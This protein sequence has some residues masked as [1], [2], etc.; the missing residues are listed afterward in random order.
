MT[1]ERGLKVTSEHGRVLPEVRECLALAAKYRM[2]ICSAHISPKE[3]M[4]LAECAQEYGI[5]EIIFSHPD[6]KSVG[7]TED[8]IKEIMDRGAV[9]EFCI[10]GFMP[11][12]QR[13]SP[14]SVFDIVERFGSERVIIT[15]D[16]F[17]DLDPPGAEMMRIMLSTLLH[18]GMK[19]ADLRNMVVGNPRRLLGNSNV[20]GVRHDK[21]PDPALQ[22][23]KVRAQA[24]TVGALR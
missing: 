15:T 3:T 1:P 8:D 20:V 11:S 23:E 6:S 7:A 21:M 24:V 14:K 2:L 22:V 19:D 10:N 16:Y 17:H 13:A 5:K 18:A 12:S 9:F 4:K